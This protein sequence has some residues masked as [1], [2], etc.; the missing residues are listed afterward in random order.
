MLGEGILVQ[1]T[2]K[3]TRRKTRKYNQTH[4]DIFL[5]QN[6]GSKSCGIIGHMK[7]TIPPSSKFVMGETSIAWNGSNHMRPMEIGVSEIAEERKR[8]H[9][10]YEIEYRVGKGDV[11]EFESDGYFEKEGE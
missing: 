9:G 10:K 4:E 1:V 3:N 2:S 7:N 8:C 11:L 5:E 6:Y